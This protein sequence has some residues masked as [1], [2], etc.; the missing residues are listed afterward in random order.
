M[1][2][3]DP[4]PQ[5]AVLGVKELCKLLGMGRSDLYEWLKD[6]T[7][8]FPAPLA[9]YGQTRNKKPLQ[10]WSKRAVYDW[11][12]AREATSPGAESSHRSERS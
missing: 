3:L 12:N 1:F 6:P 10:R 9:G 2:G 5:A 7:T 11:I 4:Y 8:G